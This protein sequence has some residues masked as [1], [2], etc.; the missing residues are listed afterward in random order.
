MG[1]LVALRLNDDCDVVM[2]LGFPGLIWVCGWIGV[3][4]VFLIVLLLAC[5]LIGF[6]LALTWCGCYAF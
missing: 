1:L 5:C 2:M 4:L 3:L 6:V